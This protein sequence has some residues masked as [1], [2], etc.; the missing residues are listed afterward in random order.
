[1]NAVMGAVIGAVLN[2]MLGTMRGPGNDESMCS[3]SS[4]CT[5]IY[6]TVS[7]VSVNEYHICIPQHRQLYVPSMQAELPLKKGFFTSKPYMCSS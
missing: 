7:L 3:V 5:P 1:M 2:A 6:N 4:M